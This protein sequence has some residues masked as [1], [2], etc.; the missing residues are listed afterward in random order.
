MRTRIISALVGTPILLALLFWPGT[1]RPFYGWP[2][3]LL[4]LVLMLTALR[5]FYNG[6][7]IGGAVP[8]EEFGYGVAVVLM[9]AA[10]PLVGDMGG[11]L[12]RFVLSLAVMLSLVVEALRRNSSPLRN[13]APLW[14]GA[15]YVGWLFPFGLRLRLIGPEAVAHLGWR[16]P[17]PWMEQFGHGPWLLLFT[18]LVTTTVDSGAYF[19]GKSIGKHKLAP[20]V[21]PGKTWEGSAGG[22]AAAILVG[23]LAAYCLGLPLR[24]ALPTAALIGVVAQLGDLSKSAIKREIGIKD[25]GSLIPGH[26]GVLDRFDS[27]LFTV[28]LVYWLLVLTGPLPH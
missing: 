24:F 7:R 12:L 26:G 25:F 8:L 1:P 21:S 20:K 3:A 23:A 17:S 22:F 6:C 10:T 5:E 2:F 9:L 14:L 19:V 11:L 28:P 4:L 27:L 18:I 15:L 16:L 13:L